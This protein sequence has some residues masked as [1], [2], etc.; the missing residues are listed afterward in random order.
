MTD[1]CRARN[2]GRVGAMRSVADLTDVTYPSK[3]YPSRGRVSPRRQRRHGAFG[4]WWI[5]VIFSFAL[6]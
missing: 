1:P 6:N 2:R 3:K 5:C 4:G